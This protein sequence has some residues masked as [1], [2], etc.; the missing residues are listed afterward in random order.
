VAGEARI[1]I[2]AEMPG[3]VGDMIERAIPDVAWHRLDDVSQ[4]GVPADCKVLVLLPSH[5][6]TNRNRPRPPGWPGHVRHVQLLSA[7]LDGYPAWVFEAP[8]VTSVRGFNAVPVAE[9]ALAAVAARA[10]RIPE[11]WVRDA[12]E[13]GYRQLGSISGAD[14]GIVGFGA[15]GSE[16][17]SRAKALGMNVSVLR[18]S[19]AHLPDGI[20]RAASLEE[21][22]A[23]CDHL[24]IAAPSTPETQ[25][26]VSRAVLAAARPGLHLVNVARGELVDEAAL[27]EALD[28]GQ[29]DWASLDVLTQEPPDAGHPLLGHPRARV[30][31]HT[32][33]SSPTTLQAL[34]AIVADNIA[35]FRSEAPL[36][37]IVTAEVAPAAASAG[38][39]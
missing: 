32:A 25:G 22:A 13:W 14:L 34:I 31:P 27:V 6:A 10:K 26:M 36:R 3:P 9:F 33:S 23:R 24:V 21:L 28:S 7:G 35:R 16:L 20:G 15:I 38:A 29:V 18:R 1:A 8:L 11:C 30:S 2:A 12:S 5:N 39:G 37:N 4:Q 19:A 17:A